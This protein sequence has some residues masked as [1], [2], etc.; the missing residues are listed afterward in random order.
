MSI[1]VISNVLGDLNLTEREK[2]D[3]ICN[4]LQ[5]Y[6]LQTDHILNCYRTLMRLKFDLTELVKDAEQDSARMITRVLDAVNTEL[7]IVEYQIDHPQLMFKNEIPKFERKHWTASVSGLV[8]IIYL[9]Q[10]C[11]DNGN[12]EIAEIAVWFEYIFHVNLKNIYKLIE[13]IASRENKTKFLDQQKLVLINFLE[14]L[15]LRKPRK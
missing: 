12:V 7:K 2:I 13:Q 6:C 5:D 9:M 1:D 3:S 15:S 14:E 10:N 8:E 4:H 11:V